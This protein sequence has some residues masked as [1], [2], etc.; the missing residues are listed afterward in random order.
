MGS[1]VPGLELREEGMELVGAFVDGLEVVL[2]F[3][4]RH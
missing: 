3:G 1:L 4:F 2:K